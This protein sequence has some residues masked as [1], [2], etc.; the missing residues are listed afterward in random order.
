MKKVIWL[1]AITAAGL[2]HAQIKFEKG[3]F[4]NNSGQRTEALIKTWTGKTIL[5]SLNSK[6]T[7]LHQK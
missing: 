7:N 1:T 2:L 5:R 4:V 3:Y 6:Q